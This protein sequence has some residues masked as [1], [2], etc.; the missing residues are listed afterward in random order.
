MFIHLRARTEFSILNSV[1][2]I[3]K[4]AEYAKSDNAGAICM[5]D[6]GSMSGSLQFSSYISKIGVK[7]LLGMNMRFI[8]DD[9]DLDEGK[10]L[11]YMGFIAKS[12]QGYK[13]LLKMLHLANVE[14]SQKSVLD[15]VY[16]KFSDLE[17]LDL[18]DLICITGGY[19]SPISREFFKGNQA[20][21][22]MIAEKL[23]KIF[24]D[25][26]YI[27]LTR[28][29][30]KDEDLLE[31]FLVDM[32]YKYNIALVATNDVHFPKKESFDSY[33]ALTCISSGRYIQEKNRERINENY[34]LKTQ[35]E[36]MELFSD[37]PEAIES[38]VVIAKKCNFY[39]EGNAPMLPKFGLN[40]N[41]DD[42]LREL[43]EKGL[44][45]RFLE[46]KIADEDVQKEYFD[47]LNFELSVIF[48]MGFSGYF[49]IVSDFIVW[50]KENNIPV[51]P[52]R[53]SGAGSII[54]WSCKITNL[55]P[56]KY[57][58]LFERFLNP[59]RV[60]MPDFDI[61]FCQS[62]R[63]KVIEYV[64][65]KYGKSRV[66]S[67]ITFGK[68]QAKAVLKDVGR[69]MQ[70]SYNMVDEVCKMIPFSP[71]EPITIEKAIQMDPKLQEQIENDP[72]IQNLVR[73]A[74]ELEG[75]NRHTSTHA[76]GIIIG[77][78]D[79]IEL[80]PMLKDENSD[81]PVLGFNMKDAEKIG[82]LK[83]DFL[84]LKTLTV[85]Q[86]AC[87]LVYKNT[88]NMIN[89]DEISL[90]D[91]TTF[92]LLRSTKLKGVFQLE[93]GT[94]RDAL[95]KIKT[96]RIEDLIAITS[97]NR[98]GPMEFIPDFVRRKLGVEQPQYPDLLL[99]KSLKETFG[100]I[101][102]QEQVMEVAKVIGGYSLG[103]ADLL[104]RAMGKKI[105]EEM[106][107]QQAIFVD[108][109]RKTHNMDEKKSS[110]IFELVAKFAGYGFNKSHAAAYSVISYQT[111]YL[112]ANYTIEFFVANLNLEI[113]NTDKINEFI[114]DARGFGL[115]II[116]P[117]VNI[118]SGYFTISEDR[119]S[120]IYGLGGLKSVGLNSAIEIEK[121]RSSDGK[122]ESIFD[123]AKKVGH[124]ICNKKQL[125]SLIL[126]GSFD[127][128]HANRKQLF[129]SVEIITKYASDLEK[130][131]N[132][133]QD[134]L[135]GGADEGGI[136]IPK[137]KDC[138]N[139]YP[140]T[141][142]LGYEME[143][144]GF[145]LSSHPLLD[146]KSVIESDKITKSSDLENIQAGKRQNIKMVGVI[147]KIV[148][149]FR[150][151]SRFCFVHLSDLD[152]IFE[153]AIFNSDLITSAR[154]LLV[155]GKLI[156][157]DISASRD[158]SGFRLIANEIKDIR[159]IASP[160]AL[161]NLQNKRAYNFTK[162]DEVND[163]K[164]PENSGENE[165]KKP[166]NEQVINHYAAIQNKIEGSKSVNTPIKAA[167]LPNASSVK[168]QEIVSE[169]SSDIVK[170]IAKTPDEILE[171]KRFCLANATEDG[172]EVVILYNGICIKM[173]N[174][175]DVLKFNLAKYE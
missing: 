36:M 33:D 160:D 138:I 5:M 174:K 15:E 142:K 115:E 11:A 152:G 63:E 4:M 3:D 155:E 150:K 57:G 89:I 9:R 37:I 92:N 175:Y 83:F 125:E 167:I 151:G 128:L 116:L 27:E 141:E 86:E 149:R 168:S 29:G 67:I 46:E 24:G 74:M 60:S 166:A 170:I 53:G 124:K 40:Q 25:D 139:D 55:D 6:D 105:K 156:F 106:D 88:G 64:K 7:P 158:D 99:E 173:P 113:N 35:S 8:L 34:Y 76:A 126:T 120:I 94:P 118:S 68:L 85:I 164:K 38:T 72:E 30:N 26:L 17:K 42:M 109:A 165:A 41:E 56:I 20:G 91:E 47:R 129:D 39:L 44:R 12:H 123:F 103:E 79:L 16:L 110:E 163:V 23:H 78:V 84:G 52:G 75:L 145:Y 49:L 111:A 162:K 102:Y 21:G 122:F 121:I 90:Q 108:G 28:H 148:Q 127:T 70:L 136:Y 97:L 140:S 87:N 114:S 69:V 54:A 131:K 132:D 13:N 143:F 14:L 19:Y 161:A 112:K 71:L 73:I 146:Y 58:L 96:D 172:K 10:K 107:A 43:S 104:R 81:L 50:A 61:D 135:F 31:N 93:A 171:I 134:N 62:K 51:G 18:S 98:P 117:N 153:I 130:S 65:N 80:A 77:A 100:I 119:K 147:T 157:L 137:L 154:E 45:E 66:A 133:T 95:A 59:E 169:I 101:I 1:L 144:I 82:L 159:D 2:T 32:A 48:K 22:F